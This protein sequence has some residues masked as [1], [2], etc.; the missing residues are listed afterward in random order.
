[1][2]PVPSLRSN[3]RQRSVRLTAK[4]SLRALLHLPR[5]QRLVAVRAGAGTIHL[6][7]HSALALAAHLGLRLH[8]ALALA[9]HLGLRLHSA[10]A[11]AAHLGLRLH[12]ALTLA[13][14]LGLWL[15]SALTLAAHLGLRLHVGPA[16][17]QHRTLVSILH[18]AALSVGT[19]LLAR[20]IVVGLMEWSLL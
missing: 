6:A 11:L 18:G 15:H 19:W 2:G 3:R 5:L 4:G 1:M 17:S 14:H 10:L 20:A 7:L 13:A 9:A 16:A 8:S 12:S